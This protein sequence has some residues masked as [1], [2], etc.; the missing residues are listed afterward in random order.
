[1]PA[2]RRAP[3]GHWLLAGRW[4]LCAPADTFPPELGKLLARVR[5]S[6]V[7]ELTTRPLSAPPLAI[8]LAPTLLELDLWAAQRAFELQTHPAGRPPLLLF[9]DTLAR[10]RGL[11]AEHIR[12]LGPLDRM[13]H[14][15][16]VRTLAGNT[17]RPASLALLHFITLH[18]GFP[19]LQRALRDHRL[20]EPT[21]TNRRPRLRRF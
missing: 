11:V 16:L 7:L 8:K 9:G 1:V 3:S 5:R 12:E 14:G 13:E 20:P 4:L 15:R 10:V 2:Q 6:Q 18:R 19:E 17:E 21:R